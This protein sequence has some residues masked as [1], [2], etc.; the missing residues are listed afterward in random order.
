MIFVFRIFIIIF[1]CLSAQAGDEQQTKKKVINNFASGAGSVLEN[2]IGGEGDTE[3]QITA[4][5]D[6]KPEF[7]IMSVRPISIHPGVDAFFIQLQANNT[8]IRGDA[9]F[10]I[11][12]GIGYRK[13]TDNK[14]AFSGGNIFLDYDEEG[15]ARASIGLELRSSAFEALANYYAA[16]SGAKTVGSYTER[17][18]DGGEISILG[19]LP[20]LPWANII[21]NH[22]EW[23]AVNNKKDSKG[24]KMSLELTITPN[25]I[26]DAGYD[27]NN[28]HGSSNFAKI[29]LVYPPRNKAAASEKFFGE[30]A[31]SNGD[32][33]NELLSKVRRTNKIILE[34]ESTG[35]VMAR[36]N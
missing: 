6:Y 13:L 15:N 2:I 3:V 20:Y 23:K 14:K 35:F 16:I 30:K 26:V 27:N 34:S 36:G 29:T 9:R 1:F 10:S 21:A 24:D 11:N 33:S 25:L 12:S 31:F 8:K 4:G 5:E 7:S 22:Y 32:M 28:I 17:A 19:E 18:L